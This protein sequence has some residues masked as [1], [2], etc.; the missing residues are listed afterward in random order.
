MKNCQ[1]THPRPQAIQRLVFCSSEQFWRNV[2]LH[3]LLT[4]G[5]SAVNGCR[6]NDTADKNI[7]NPQVIQTSPVH[8]LTIIGWILLVRVDKN[9]L[10]IQYNSR[11]LWQCFLNTNNNPQHQ[12]SRVY[13]HC[14]GFQCFQPVLWLFYRSTSC[15]LS[16]TSIWVWGSNHHCPAHDRPCRWVCSR[17]IISHAFIHAMRLWE[18][19]WL[20]TIL[21]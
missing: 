10:Y 8:L 6:Q 4:F 20:N 2:A 14:S 16:S 7:N 21:T 13:L 19:L 15:T 9:I 11:N 18:S 17:P 12:T 1:C 3:H 5:S